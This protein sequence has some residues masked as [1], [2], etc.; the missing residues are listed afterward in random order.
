MLAEWAVSSR[1]HL[2]NDGLKEAIEN[3]Q[4]TTGDDIRVIADDGYFKKD[5]LGILSFRNEFDP[6][7]IAWFKDRALSRHEQFN[8]Y[9]KRFKILEE[10]FS[11][12]H[13]SGKQSKRRIP[14]A[15]GVRG[16]HLCYSPVRA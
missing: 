15:Q 3:L 6:R 1:Y 9:T 5:L 8:G 2:E 4:Q 11:H 16:G 10:R 14:N 12:D 7:D 13:T